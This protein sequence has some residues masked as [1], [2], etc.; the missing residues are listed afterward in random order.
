MLPL[1]VMLLPPS[2]VKAFPLHQSKTLRSRE[3]YSYR[4]AAFPE[5]DPLKS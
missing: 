4:Q 3:K 1:Y 2:Q 5:K